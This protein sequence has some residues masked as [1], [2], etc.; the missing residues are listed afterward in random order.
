[1]QLPEF[2][3]KYLYSLK[4]DEELFELDGYRLQKFDLT[5][6]K[7]RSI[8]R[9]LD[10][11]RIAASAPN[12]DEVST[13]SSEPTID[14][15]LV[16]M[17][18]STR[19][20]KKPKSY[21][22]E[23]NSPNRQVEAEDSSALVL[24]AVLLGWIRYCELEKKSRNINS[25]I[26]LPAVDNNYLQDDNETMRT[27]IFSVSDYRTPPL[28]KRRTPKKKRPSKPM[29]PK[30]RKTVHCSPARQRGNLINSSFVSDYNGNE[31]NSKRISKYLNTDNISSSSC[32]ATANTA[33]VDPWDSLHDGRSL[34]TKS[35]IKVEKKEI[36]NRFAVWSA[37]GCSAS[38]P[39]TPP[40]ISKKSAF[41]S[42]PYST[43]VPYSSSST[44]KGPG[45]QY[46][47]DYQ[48]AGCLSI[49]SVDAM[50]CQCSKGSDESR[51][52]LGTP[53]MGSLDDDAI[54]EYEEM[55]ID[56]ESKATTRASASQS[57]DANKE[58]L[59]L[60]TSSF[61]DRAILQALG[62]LDP[63]NGCPR[64]QVGN[65]DDLV[66]KW[67]K[68]HVGMNPLNIDWMGCPYH[69]RDTTLLGCATS[70]LES[71]RKNQ[72]AKEA[73]VSEF[74]RLRMREPSFGMV[75]YMAHQEQEMDLHIAIQSVCN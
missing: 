74:R 39:S 19:G 7:Q 64:E 30:N 2:L 5:L 18:V 20:L 11:K 17:K 16:S 65:V 58:N 24:E 28:S 51:S 47:Q 70:W 38:I 42:S 10:A 25:F 43:R 50:S 52:L 46:F 63:L 49:D 61:T 66:R 27:G 32:S 23:T 33:T 40:E 9:K 3:E 4:L 73:R 37:P 12:S 1:M 21:S 31:S 6:K 36:Q 48:E 22:T 62:E 71:D 72:Q 59:G 75:R 60:K 44:R 55:A 56:E 15:W 53:D 69:S 29:S 8:R 41:A 35:I 26:E 57:F 67:H 68:L 14:T 45:R 34:E 13:V 54:T